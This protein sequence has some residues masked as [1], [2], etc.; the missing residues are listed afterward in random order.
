MTTSGLH[1]KMKM[2]VVFASCSPSSS[3]RTRLH[4]HGCKD[5]KPKRSYVTRADLTTRCLN[6]PQADILPPY[7]ISKPEPKR[8]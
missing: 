2:E 4:P 6:S 8:S 5:G 7:K 1:P 3:L